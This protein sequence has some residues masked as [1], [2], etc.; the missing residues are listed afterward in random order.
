MRRLAPLALLIA[1]LL[2]ALGG[3]TGGGTTEGV[4]K[5]VDMKKDYSPLAK[6]VGPMSP[7]EAKKADAA[8]KK[9]AKDAPKDNDATP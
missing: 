9:T 4:P 8:A 5:D 7:A 3:C 6:P 1:S 2:P